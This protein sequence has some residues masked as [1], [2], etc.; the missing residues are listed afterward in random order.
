[1]AEQEQQSQQPQQGKAEQKKNYNTGLIS[2]EIV[3]KFN[4]ID[5]DMRSI[6]RN[7]GIE[8]VDISPEEIIRIAQNEA[9][10]IKKKTIA[11]KD[12]EKRY[13]LPAIVRLKD[14]S[15]NVVLAIKHDENKAMILDPREQSPK[16]VLLD[17]FQNELQDFVLVLK[18]KLLNDEVKFG[19]KWFF[20]EI[21]KYKK[22]VGQSNYLA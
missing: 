3:A 16:A 15:Y 20:V 13:P 11:L 1:M 19:F 22:I 2:L 10:K 18:H 12:M 5:I 21:L 6:V 7:Y 17:E 9:F 8:S 14:D 4:Q